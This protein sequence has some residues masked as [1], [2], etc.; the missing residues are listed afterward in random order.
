MVL[1]GAEADPLKKDGMRGFLITSIVIG[2]VDYGGLILLSGEFSYLTV[3][4]W[5]LTALI[6]WVAVFGIGLY[7]WGPRFL[8]SLLGLPLVLLPVASVVI[9]TG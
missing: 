2:A 5:I 8:W 4:T 9:A 1:T 3:R 7:R 6:L